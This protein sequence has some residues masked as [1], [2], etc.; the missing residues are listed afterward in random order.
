MKRPALLG[1]LLLSACVQV[2]APVAN[3]DASVPPEPEVALDPRT[4][5]RNFA[6][7]VARMEPVVESECRVRL[8]GNCDFQ[9]I[10]DTSPG[11]PPNAFQTRDEAGRPI[12]AFTVP[13]IAMARNQD[14]LA[15]VMGHEA[16]H[17]I[18]DHIPRQRQTAILGAA[19]FGAMTA[20]SGGDPTAIK[21]AQDV[22]AALGARTYSKDFEL[23]ADQ[24]GTILAWN[25]GFD[26]ERGAFFFE[27]LP[28]PGN[29]F[30]GTHP[31]NAARPQVVRET[32]PTPRYSLIRINARRS[33]RALLPRPAS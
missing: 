24:L 27:R 22:G 12:I 14:E 20:A 17:H 9:I 18:L 3:P 32:L 29:R 33:R 16:A 2:G 31:P 26:P 19:V 23:E 15:F 6:T 21:S 1:F 11:A 5:A 25:A 7:V 10:V 30:L 4:A 28:D 13:L 8:G